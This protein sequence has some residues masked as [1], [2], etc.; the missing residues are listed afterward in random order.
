MGDATFEFICI[1]LRMLSWFFFL[2]T[3]EAFALCIRNFFVSAMCN[4]DLSIQINAAAGTSGR[5]RSFKKVCTF[6]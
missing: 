1:S 5:P 6:C 3:L 2:Y 4:F